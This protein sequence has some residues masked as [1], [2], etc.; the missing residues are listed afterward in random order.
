LYR[1]AM[2]LFL[3]AAK[4]TSIVANYCRVARDISR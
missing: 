2:L 1:G 3:K 4:V